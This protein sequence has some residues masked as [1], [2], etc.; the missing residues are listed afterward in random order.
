M[1]YY[2]TTAINILVLLLPAPLL[3]LSLGNNTVDTAVRSR[4]HKEVVT[5]QVLMPFAHTEK[6]G[7]GAVE[8]VKKNRKKQ[9]VLAYIHTKPGKE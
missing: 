4:L 7:T 1:Q 8:E 9:V 6:L 2:T 5:D 3:S